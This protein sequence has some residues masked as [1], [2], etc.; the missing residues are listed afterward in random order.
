MGP[1]RGKHLRNIAIILALALAVWLLPGGGQAS[2]TISNLLGIV[3]IAGILFFGYRIYM[4]RR[5]VLFGLEERQRGILYAA[6]ALAVITLVAT[7][8]MWD[9]GGLGA[10]FWLAFMGIAFYGVYGVWRASREY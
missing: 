1:D 7:S 6:V 5:D 10:V 2:A 8:R 4:E 3:F 9:S